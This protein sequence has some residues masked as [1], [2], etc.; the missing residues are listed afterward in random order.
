M[1]APASDERKHF[2][3]SQIPIVQK[4]GSVSEKH[5]WWI[6][7]KC[8]ADHVNS[9]GNLAAPAL[10]RDRADAYRSHLKRCPYHQ[11]ELIVESAVEEP[12]ST[13][14]LVRSVS[15]ISSSGSATAKR[16]KRMSD[17]FL[18]VEDQRSFECDLLEFQSECALPDYFIERTSTKMLFA[19]MLH[20]ELPTR[21]ELGG[22]I[23]K[24]NAENAEL[25][26]NESLR[27]MQED[28]EGRVNFISDVWQNVARL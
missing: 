14:S 7:K 28:T 12:R 3:K 5:H 24:I 2:G 23:L 27:E 25:A 13:I 18:S 8:Q 11:R 1:P 22:R 26:S 10:V 6:C 17:F 4:D 21:K 20:F 15:S 16:Q 19:R 9:A